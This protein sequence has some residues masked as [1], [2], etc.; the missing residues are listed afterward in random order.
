MTTKYK[1]G[2]LVW[3]KMRGFPP[4]PGMISEP[5]E[6]M[7]NKPK[8]PSNWIYFFGSKNYSWIDV[9]NLNPYKPQAL[10]LKKSSKAF[11]EACEAIED[12][13]NKGEASPFNPQCEDNA[14][15]RL[16]GEPSPAKTPKGNEPSTSKGK[17]SASAKKKSAAKDAEKAKRRNSVGSEASDTSEPSKKKSKS[18]ATPR[19]KKG[20]EEESDSSS[21]FDETHSVKKSSRPSK[22]GHSGKRP[23]LTNRSDAKRPRTQHSDAD[24]TTPAGWSI[25][26]VD[27]S[28]PIPRRGLAAASLLD[29]PPNIARPETT[30]LDISKVSQTLLDKNITPSQLKFGFLGLGNMGSGIVKNLLNSGH[31]VVIWNRTSEKTKEFIKAGAEIACTPQDVVQSADITFSCVTDTQAAKDMMFGNC[32]ALAEV[33]SS[34]AY[35][36]M[37]TIDAVTSKDLSDAV[38]SRGGRYLEAQLQGSRAEAEEGTLLILS[39]GD[40]TLYNECHSCFEAFGRCS[41]YFGEV[42]SATKM[43]L[44]IQLMTGVFLAGCAESLALADKLGLQLSDVIEVIGLTKLACPYVIEKA[45]NIIGCSYGTDQALRLMQKDL[46]LVLNTSQTVNQPVPLAAMANELYKHAKRVGYA[47]HDVAAIFVR[48]RF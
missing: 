32:G 10:D 34:K 45:K 20:S 17:G 3:A 24:T 18:A 40:K 47:D 38:T 28:T 35:V 37:T 26:S 43:N 8:K 6:D 48:T 9:S 4:W 42:G 7:T 21:D 15:D 23:S 27:Y 33:N 22:D 39:A 30:P 16:F 36:E 41:F 14:F 12:V 5:P 19:K 11:K 1:L 13:Y 44:V 25:G 2:D 29:R 46:S 31:R